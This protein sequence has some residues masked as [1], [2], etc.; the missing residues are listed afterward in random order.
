VY[1]ELNCYLRYR[2]RGHW[3]KSLVS[4]KNIWLANIGMLGYTT[5]VLKSLWR[6]FDFVRFLVEL[7]F[8]YSPYLTKVPSILPRI[9]NN[10]ISTTFFD[11]IN[12]KI[13]F[14]TVSIFFFRTITVVI[15]NDTIVFKLWEIHNRFVICL[16]VQRLA[17]SKVIYYPPE[18]RVSFKIWE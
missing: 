12:T 5:P 11:H 1:T 9:S 4:E 10:K 7:K 2:Y 18:K 17:L 16:P 15:I 3:Q 14:C 13:C 8:F 6:L